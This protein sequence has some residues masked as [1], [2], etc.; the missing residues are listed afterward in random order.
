MFIHSDTSSRRGRHRDRLRR[1]IRARRGIAVGMTQELLEF[2]GRSPRRRPQPDEHSI[3]RSSS[4]TSRRSEEAS[5]SHAHRRVA[6]G[7][8]RRRVPGTGGHPA[9]RASRSMGVA[10][11]RRRRRARLERRHRSGRESGKRQS[12]LQT[13]HQGHRRDD[14]DRPWPARLSIGDRDRQD[15]CLR[16][17]IL[18]PQRQNW[19]AA[20]GG[21][22][23][24]G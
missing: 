9:L 17:H 10:T 20:R 14:S 6:F 2:P 13:R 23:G 18:Q 22:G 8:R 24:R 16:R 7:S 1:R 4:V 12:P 11:S 19:G 3:G 5:K 15:R 21:G